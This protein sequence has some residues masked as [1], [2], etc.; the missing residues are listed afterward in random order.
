[1]QVPYRTFITLDD[2]ERGLRVFD[3]NVPGEEYGP[4][5]GYIGICA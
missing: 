5:V 2:N 1:M 4:L 3:D